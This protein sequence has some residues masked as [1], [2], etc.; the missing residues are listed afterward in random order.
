MPEENFNNVVTAVAVLYK[1]GTLESP[2][3]LKTSHQTLLEKLLVSASQVLCFSKFL[4][5]WELEDVLQPYYGN[6][7]FV[8]PFTMTSIEWWP[9]QWV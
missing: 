5:V 3:S 6:Y 8:G 4:R 1:G 2:K 9:V 7:K